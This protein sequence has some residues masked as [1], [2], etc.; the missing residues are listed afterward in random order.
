MFEFCF[1]FNTGGDFF[2]AVDFCLK[3][4]NLLVLTFY[5]C[6]FII[7]KTIV[8]IKAGEIRSIDQN[9]YT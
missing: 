4:I 8:K 2:S 9:F 7:K 6:S 1:Y 5:V 3:L